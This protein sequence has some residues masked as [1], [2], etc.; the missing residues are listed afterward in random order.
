MSE[1]WD[2]F[3]QFFS[4]LKQ[5]FSESD[6]TYATALFAALI[7][8]ASFVK[9]VRGFMYSTIVQPIGKFFS[10]F[11]TLSDRLK[12]LESKLAANSD[13]TA[14]LDKLE[15][16]QEEIKKELSPNSGTT[17]KDVI[18]TLAVSV[19]K[20]ERLTSSISEQT[21][22]SEVRQ[23]Y[24]FE[25]DEAPT[26][27]TD[28]EGHYIFA[29]KAFQKLIGRGGK[30]LH[31]FGWIN[32]IHPDDRVKVK[33]ELESAIHDRRNFEL[34]YRIVCK[35]KIIYEVV[36]EALPLEGKGNGYIGRFQS[37]RQIGILI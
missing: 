21:H 25:T 19:K 3:I 30:E 24:L 37:V 12:S 1:L 15:T 6:L 35:E 23:Q 9:R 34:T 17:I 20:I 8:L 10:T 14:R 31:G 29:N 18:N 22:R 5:T 4:L 2:T 33:T 26:F 28:N 13:L 27:E 36:C 16:V 32:I 7:A 11:T